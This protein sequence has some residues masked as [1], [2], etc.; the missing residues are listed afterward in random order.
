MGRAAVSY[1]FERAPS[2]A[3]YFA[4]ALFGRRRALLPPGMTLPRLQGEIAAV[5][6]KAR[7][8]ARY[9]DVCGYAD[10]GLLP[11][12]YPHVLASPLQVA[13]AT[14]PRFEL[15]LMGLV[16]VSN[17]IRALRPLPADGT[18]RVGCRVEG[19][20]DTDRGQEVDLHTCL[21]DQAGLA[22]AERST[23]LARGAPRPAGTARSARTLLSMPRPLDDARPA[24]DSFPADRA[25][26]RRYGLVSGD[27]NPIHLANWSAR[28]YG[29]DRA[30]AHGMWSMARTLA[31]LGP[32]LT[33][34]PRRI[35][36]QFKLP[37]YLPGSGVVMHWLEDDRW[38]FTVRDG[39]S[40]RPHLAGAAEPL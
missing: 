8:L 38:L 14:H 15:R 18:Y 24:S 12:A 17:E 5:R 4:R 23:L 11:I 20:R 35:D 9:R 34:V 25:A 3:R 2:A 33:T 6:V 40:Q 32:T 28:R 13:L 10:D 16:H 39:Q 21:Y 26:G 37:L 27:L 7:H 19:H 30:V 1:E 22:W 31:C 29:F 36:V